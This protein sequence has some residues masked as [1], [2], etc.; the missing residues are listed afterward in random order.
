MCRHSAGAESTEVDAIAEA[1][2]L[3]PA[4][5]CNDIAG[6]DAEE[7]HLQQTAALLSCAGFLFWNSVYSSR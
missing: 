5:E 4:S 2:G 1:S 7:F 6:K 3:Q